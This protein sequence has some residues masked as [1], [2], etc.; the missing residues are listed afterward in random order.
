MML[1]CVCMIFG[2]VLIVY[3]IF[4]FGFSRL[5][6][7]KIVCFFMLNC[8]LD[9]CEFENGILGMLCGIIFIFELGIVYV[10][11]KIFVFFCVIIIR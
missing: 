7:S 10:F 8:V 5:K 4:F 1:G 11:C 3:L 6:V 9:N 2:R